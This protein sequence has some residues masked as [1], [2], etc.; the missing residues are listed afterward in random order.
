MRCYFAPTRGFATVKRKLHILVAEDNRDIR[1]FMI[2]LS[3]PEF[4]VVGAVSN[5]RELVRVALEMLPDVIVSDTSMPLLGRVTAM[6]ELRATGTNIPVVLI[7]AVFRR[8][9]TSR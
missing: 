6:N 9:G 1:D 8:A 3:R 4:D 5:G 2:G 7:S